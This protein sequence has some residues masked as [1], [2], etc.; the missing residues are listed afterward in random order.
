[1]SFQYR[2]APSALLQ[3]LGIERLY[4]FCCV[5]CVQEVNQFGPSVFEIIASWLV[6][7]QVYCMHSCSFC[8]MQCIT[9][10]EMFSLFLPRCSYASEVFLWAS[11]HPSVK[12][13][14]CDNTKV[15]SEKNS[16]MTNRK[17]PMSFPVSL[18]WTG[19]VALTPK[20]GL[21][22]YFFR[23]LYKNGL[24]SKKVCYKVSLCDPPPS[25]TATSYRYSLVAPEQ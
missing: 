20:G 10:I 4:L 18:R 11:V 16:I 13:V 23:F 3:R 7:I 19:Y 15:P 1:M 8:C 24:F 17:S 21:K 14:D 9:V 6:G 2:R 5:Q 12:R 22:S 25:K